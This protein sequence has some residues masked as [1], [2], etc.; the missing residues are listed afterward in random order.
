MI[1]K[2]PFN[3]PRCLQYT[4]YC[5]LMLQT[6]FVGRILPKFWGRNMSSVLVVEDFEP[7]R[8]F[9]CST[10]E[11]ELHVVGEVADGKRYTKLSNYSPT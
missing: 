9:V 8:R 11:P 4:L 2:A 6:S 3:R 10:I 7:F 5:H 1:R